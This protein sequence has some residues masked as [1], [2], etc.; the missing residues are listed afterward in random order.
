MPFAR[1][2]LLFCFLL[3]A[4]C[5]SHYHVAVDSL[6]DDRPPSGSSYVLVPGNEGMKPTD[7]QFRDIARQ[8][9][10]AFQSK[11]YT[12]V[13]SDAQNK[14]V[15]SWWMEDPRVYLDTSTVTR[16]HPV[17][18]GYGRHSYV[19]Y[20]FVDEPVVT[21][22]TLY[23]AN[24]LIEAYELDKDGREGRQIWRTALR[25]TAPDED[26]HTLFFSMLQVLPRVIGTRSHGLRRYD[27]F[28]GS[29]GEIEVTDLQNDSLF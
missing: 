22:T 26:F 20:I 23:S 8:L 24:L 10:P 5:G 1:L 6:I 19:D 27:V 25:C 2:L 28:L 15:I 11:G 14:A 17:V 18:V 21:S 4:G 3:L 12:V 16:A 29:E 7:L 13:D 9:T